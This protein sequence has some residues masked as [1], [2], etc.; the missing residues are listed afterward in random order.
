MYHIA[1]KGGLAKPVE[2]QRAVHGHSFAEIRRDWQK[3]D[4]NLGTRLPLQ[5]RTGSLPPSGDTVNGPVTPPDVA[6][7]YRT[8]GT[9]P[10]QSRCSSFPSAACID[11]DC[12]TSAF[13]DNA[14]ASTTENTRLLLVL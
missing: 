3:P 10:V 13:A 12:A 7:G 11:P 14:I 9:A 8:A 1:R 4:D 5:R 2:P 6:S